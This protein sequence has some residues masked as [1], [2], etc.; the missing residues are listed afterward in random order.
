MQFYWSG[1]ETKFAVVVLVRFK[2]CVLLGMPRAF[3]TASLLEISIA[4]GY[5]ATSARK[6]V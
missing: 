3:M 6:D 5:S 1:T 4:L 2:Q